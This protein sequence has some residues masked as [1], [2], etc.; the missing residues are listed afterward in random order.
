MELTCKHWD[1]LRESPERMV[2]D[3]VWVREGFVILLDELRL[4]ASIGVSF[5]M[6]LAYRL[7]CFYV[8]PSYHR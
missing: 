7:A 2:L 8:S 3:Y 5:V 6:E 4:S 1:M